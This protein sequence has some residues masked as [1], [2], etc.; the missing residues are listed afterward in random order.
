MG[1]AYA[2]VYLFPAFLITVGMWFCSVL[3]LIKIALFADADVHS[4]IAACFQK[5]LAYLSHFIY[6]MLLQLFACI[7][8]SP[9][10]TRSV[11]EQDYS[12]SIWIFIQN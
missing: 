3:L 2:V 8:V 5:I 12:F 11:S 4:C 10:C 7:H 1:L 6:K 9:V